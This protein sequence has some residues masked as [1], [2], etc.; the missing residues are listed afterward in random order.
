MT[1]SSRISS[2]TGFA[3][4]SGADSASGWS[5]EVRSV[6]G[7]ALDIRCRPPQGL[8]RLDPAVRNAVSARLLTLTVE[9][10]K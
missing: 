2:M 3:R 6:N 9:S 5:W 8:E 10:R 1:D 7:R 4:A